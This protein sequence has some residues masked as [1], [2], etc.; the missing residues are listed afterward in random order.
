MPTVICLGAIIFDTILR[1]PAVVAASAKVLASECVQLGAGMASSAAAAI[2]RLGGRAELWGRVGDDMA[3]R[4]TLAD[5]A[6]A[7]VDVGRVRV[8]P[9]G[10]TPVSTILVDAAGQRLVVPF[11]DPALDRNS[12]WLPVERVAA[13]DVVLADPR[14]PEGSARLLEAARAAGKPAVL[15]GDVAP[16]PVLERLLPLASHPVLSEPALASLVGEIGVEPGLRALAARLDG[17]VGV[18]AGERGFFWWEAGHI[19]H[20]PAPGIAV[21][22]TLS[23]GDVFHGAFALALAEGQA[24]ADAGRFACVAASLK[25]RRF[26]GRLG[27]PG[28]DEVDAFLA[29]GNNV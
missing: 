27:A 11:Y 14:W 16:L 23:A 3:G 29:S 17:P 6:A 2:A 21:V 7:G 24:I 9:G 13:A 15:D 12:S 4:Q 18:T 22:D 1:V 10:R 20:V 26:G 5:L 8:C 28:R 25:C 19:N